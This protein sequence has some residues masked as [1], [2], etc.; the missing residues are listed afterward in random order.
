M[1]KYKRDPVRFDGLPGV[2]ACWNPVRLVKLY[3]I[4]GDPSVSTKQ[5][6]SSAAMA[7]RVERSTVTKKINSIDWD[8]FTKRLY[9]LCTMSDDSFMEEAAEQYRINA[10]ARD[11]LQRR[12]NNITRLAIKKDL[13]AKIQ[14]A[15][16]PK[17]RIILPP[18]RIEKKRTTR[19]PEHMV[20]LL[21]DQHV[22]LDFT[23][24]DTGGLNEY[25]VEIYQHRIENLRKGLIEIYR[26]HSELYP[27]PELHVLCLGDIVQ[28]TNLGGAWNPGYISSEMSIDRQATVAANM[29]CELLSTWSNFFQKVHFV[30]IIGNHGRAGPVKNTDK[31]QANW[32]NVV[33]SY[34]ERTMQKHTNVIVRSSDT[35]WARKNINGTEFAL[36]HGDNMK[37]SPNSIRAEEQ[38]MQSLLSS[39]GGPFQILVAGH[40]HSHQEIETTAG[41]VLLNGSFVGGDIFSMKSLSLKSKPTQTVIGVHPK[42][43]V[44]WKYCIDLSS[45]RE[46]QTR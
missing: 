38:R 32:D 23:L 14:A 31:V 28:G 39:E 7:L 26:L 46:H 41:R 33:Y 42:H 2:T 13:E 45:D 25:N 4:L 22:G 40:F 6:H 10:L 11:A 35:W 43:G 37:S 44:T 34:I 19:T 21:S 15:C 17:E 20:L 18:L 36:V 24:D 12:K 30:G 9:Q 5:T 27:I 16:D 29:M 1:S 3:K 8:Q